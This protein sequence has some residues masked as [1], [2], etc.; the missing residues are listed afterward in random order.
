MSAKKGQAEKYRLYL[1]F[2]CCLRSTTVYTTLLTIEINTKFF[3][4]FL[5]ANKSQA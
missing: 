3:F 1:V 4:Y 2:Y 5:R